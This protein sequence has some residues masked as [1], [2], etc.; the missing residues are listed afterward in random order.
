MKLC[1]TNGIYY[2]LLVNGSVIVLNTI[3][4][5]LGNITIDLFITNNYLTVLYFI[6]LST[7]MHS[8][9]ASIGQT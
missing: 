4:L 9:V 1:I 8:V 2:N 6:N 7:S 5:L 3:I